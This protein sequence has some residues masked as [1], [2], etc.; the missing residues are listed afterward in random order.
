MTPS[1]RWLVPAGV[2]VAAAAALLVAVGVAPSPPAGAPGSPGGHGQPGPSAASGRLEAFSVDRYVA[3]GDS[4]TAGPLIPYVDASR[5]TCLRSSA[6]YPAVLGRWLGA[7]RV[8]DNSCSGA[9][10][11]D[12][13]AQATAVTRATDLVTVGMGGNDFDLFATLV[14]RCATLAERASDAPCRDAF[15]RPDGASAVRSAIQ[16]V[17]HRLARG[18]QDIR[19]RAPGAVLAV[20]GY[21][22]IVP[23]GGTCDAL[24]FAPGDYGFADQVERALNRALAAAAAR[25]GSTYVDTYGP[26]LGHDA[27]AGARAWVNGQRSVATEALAYHPFVAGMRASAEAAYVAL[28][29]APPT[30]RMLTE[31]E[32]Q[33]AIRPAGSLTL[34][35][36]RV[37]AAVFTGR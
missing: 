29:G 17:E 19:R 24:P 18:L 22:R 8:V 26:S 7:E 3:L 9:D 14:G 31:A 34:R 2:L 16:R 12:L 15:A 35:E 33:A 4:F 21:P 6:N 20:V 11:G 23:L 1:A 28:T 13:A 10:T 25:T 32:Q 37:L 27:C 36:Q 5:T 30:S